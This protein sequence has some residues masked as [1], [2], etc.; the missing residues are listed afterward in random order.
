VSSY[1]KTL[2]FDQ[3]QI[4]QFSNINVKTVQYSRHNCVET[5]LIRKKRRFEKNLTVPKYGPFYGYFLSTRLLS[6]GIL[7]HYIHFF[8]RN[9]ENH[10]CIFLINIWVFTFLLFSSIWEKSNFPLQPINEVYKPQFF[11]SHIII[12]KH[13]ALDKFTI[14]GGF[15]RYIPEKP[16]QGPVGAINFDMSSSTHHAVMSTRVPWGH[17]WLMSS[18]FP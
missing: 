4:K 3:L 18:C 1:I 17:H 16:I 12:L 8:E 7:F 6:C 13:L 15:W 2:M 14:H 9:G 10:D 11:L 5:C